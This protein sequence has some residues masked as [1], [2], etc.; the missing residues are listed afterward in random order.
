MALTL[1]S[2]PINETR[3]GVPAIG[4]RRIVVR[5][6]AGAEVEVEFL[7]WGQLGIE[8][9]GLFEGAVTLVGE[10]TDDQIVARSDVTLYADAEYVLLLLRCDAAVRDG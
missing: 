4:L 3:D 2:E 7:A 5:D 6:S 9:A 1:H 10:R 8:I